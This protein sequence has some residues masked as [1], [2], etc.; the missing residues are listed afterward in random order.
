MKEKIYNA[1]IPSK[2]ADAKKLVE[3]CLSF[4]NENIEN[5]SSEAVQD[6]KLVLCELLYNAVIH[7][8]NEDINKK[9]S[10]SIK[11]EKADVF[12]EISDEG[13]GFDYEGVISAK[14]ALSPEELLLES[15]RGILLA[16]ALVDN[17]NF[18]KLGNV[19]EFR[20]KVGLNG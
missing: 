1:I 5:A 9:V 6:I 17:M 19:I 2:I 8:N 7:G 20:K 4:V 3:D 15:G 13:E 14:K 11:I 16:M 10:L 18:N 12:V